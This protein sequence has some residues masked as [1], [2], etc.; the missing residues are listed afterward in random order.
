M[1][2]DSSYGTYLRRT[3]PELCEIDP[4]LCG[5][6]ID[7]EDSFP[8]FGGG[9]PPPPPGSQTVLGGEDS[10]P[11]RPIIEIVEVSPDPSTTVLGGDDSLPP[12]PE[13]EIVN[14]EFVPKI[15]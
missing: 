12:P 13:I 15:K 9:P 11:P 4:T 8:I 1:G 2:I 14:E 5:P 7:D 6:S 10:L 3:N